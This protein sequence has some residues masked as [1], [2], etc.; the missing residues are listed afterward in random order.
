MAMKNHSEIIIFL[1]VQ[2]D[3]DALGYLKDIY[4]DRDPVNL[5]AFTLEFVSIPRFSPLVQSE[6][7]TLNGL[8]S[9]LTRTL[10]S[11]TRF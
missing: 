4:V 1:Q 11:L 9:T 7:K 6:L 5:R 10:T 3:M 8:L 2:E